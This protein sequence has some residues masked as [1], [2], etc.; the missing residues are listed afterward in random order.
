M[1]PILRIVAQSAISFALVSSV[2]HAQN[3]EPGKITVTGT[4]TV[5]A[6]PDIA[7]IS[8]GVLREAKT[9][10]RALDENTKAMA[11]IFK[12]M[13]AAGIADRDIQTSQFSIQPKYVYPKQSSSGD[14]PAPRIV[15]YSVTNNLTIRVRKLD[16]TGKILD[17]VVSLGVNS[18]GNIQFRNSNT[19]D[20]L[21]EAREKAVENAKKK[22]ATLAETAGVRMGRVLL[23]SEPVSQTVGTDIR[24]ARL[25]VA[26]AEGAAV[27]IAAGEQEYRVNV[28]VTWEL[29]Q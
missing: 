7:L 15:G 11:A 22:A 26:A 2:A 6:K 29:V 21:Q 23:I 9:A 16:D 27:P 1:N 10:R 4:G 5:A 20:L 25:S 8:F 19:F 12:A 14:Q 18:G 28:Q 3:V 24:R 13:K 17:Q